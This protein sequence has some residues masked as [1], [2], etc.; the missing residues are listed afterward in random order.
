MFRPFSVR[1]RGAKLLPVFETLLTSPR[2]FVG[3]VFDS[4]LGPNG[5]WL[6]S[7]KPQQ[8]PVC[9]KGNPLYQEAWNYYYTAVR[10]GDLWP[11]DEATARE[12]DVPFDPNF[13]GE[14]S[15]PP[16][17]SS[18]FVSSANPSADFPTHDSKE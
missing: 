3:R 9:P 14:H 7:D 12:C 16:V 18:P 4:S 15:A 6:F 2:R 1:A 13:G 11:A 5:G 8:V 17:F 10:D